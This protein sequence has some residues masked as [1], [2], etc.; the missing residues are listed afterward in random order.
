M[1]GAPG[2]ASETWQTADHYRRELIDGF[3]QLWK[4]KKAAATRQTAA[5]PWFQRRWLPK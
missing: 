2:L 1:L 3:Y 5:A 4:T